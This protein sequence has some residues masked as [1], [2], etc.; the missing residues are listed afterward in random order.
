MPNALARLKTRLQDQGGDL[1]QLREEA[2]IDRFFGAHN[3][4]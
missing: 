2:G 1:S 4:L 3:A